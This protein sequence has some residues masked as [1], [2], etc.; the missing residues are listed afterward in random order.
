MSYEEEDTCLVPQG[1][2]DIFINGKNVDE[3]I[4]IAR[5]W[6]LFIPYHF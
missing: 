1:G 2:S 4:L 3:F 6:L 5:C